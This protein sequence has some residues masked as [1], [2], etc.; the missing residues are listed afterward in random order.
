ME[1]ECVLILLNS[2]HLNAW[3]QIIE[4]LSRVIIVEKKVFMHGMV[5]LATSFK[6]KRHNEKTIMSITRDQTDDVL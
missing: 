4:H 2:N 1:K 6:T 3:I 5:Y